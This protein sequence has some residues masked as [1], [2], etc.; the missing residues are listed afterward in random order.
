[1]FVGGESGK[2]SREFD[3]N[4][5]PIID[6]LTVLITFLLASAAFLAIGQLTA[7][8]PSMKTTRAELGDWNLGA[9]S[10][11]VDRLR[12]EFPDLVSVTLSAQDDVEYESY[13]RVMESLRSHISDVLVGGF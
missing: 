5:A 3:L 11:E 7:A 13:I 10:S 12:R 8:G 2:K 6:C 4:L 9:L 1:M